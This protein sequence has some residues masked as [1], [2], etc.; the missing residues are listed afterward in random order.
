MGEEIEDT[1]MWSRAWSGGELLRPVPAPPRWC[2]DDRFKHSAWRLNRASNIQG[3][4]F[5]RQVGQGI[6]FS[7]LEIFIG[8]E[9]EWID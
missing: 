3:L 4:G 1:K 6:Y 5:K 9:A 2:E 8:R 7:L